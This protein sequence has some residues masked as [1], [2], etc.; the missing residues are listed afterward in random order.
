MFWKSTPKS[1]EQDL[2]LL[3]FIGVL[4]LIMKRLQKKQRW[5]HERRLIQLRWQK[6]IW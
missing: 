6:Y 4:S 3:G 1:M 5:T 2:D